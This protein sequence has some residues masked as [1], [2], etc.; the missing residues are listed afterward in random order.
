MRR[1]D[2]HWIWTVFLS[3]SSLYPQVSRTVTASAPTQLPAWPKVF[4]DLK[5]QWSPLRL[6]TAWRDPE[7]SAV[8]SPPLLLLHQPPL[9]NPLLSCMSRTYTERFLPLALPSLHKDAEDPYTSSWPLPCSS[10]DNLPYHR[11]NRKTSE[12][13]NWLTWTRIDLRKE[14]QSPL[15]FLS[16]QHLRGQRHD[17]VERKCTQEVRGNAIMANS[18]VDYVH[19]R[20]TTKCSETASA[21]SV[22]LMLDWATE[23]G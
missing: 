8:R 18:L 11:K 4:A 14:E 3:M 5:W 13:K 7:T 12:E 20:V 6:K 9:P 16:S 23:V 15:F 21:T 22:E 10:G 1:E 2:F 19:C 17:L